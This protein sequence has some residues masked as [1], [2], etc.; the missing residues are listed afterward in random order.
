MIMHHVIHFYTYSQW[1][2]TWFY[3]CTCT[4]WAFNSLIHSHYIDRTP[5]G[6]KVNCWRACHQ[7]QQGFSGQTRW[8]RGPQACSKWLTS[9]SGHWTFTSSASSLSLLNHWKHLVDNVSFQVM[10][11][12]M[13]CIQPMVSD[14]V[15]ETENTLK[16]ILFLEF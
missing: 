7:V 3:N 1:N 8:I 15:L 14:S 2:L 13:L 16:N 12:G 6:L 5:V 11:K 10:K 4:W 9:S